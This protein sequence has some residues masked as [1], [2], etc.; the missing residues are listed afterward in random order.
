MPTA[1]F[2]NG[3]S[4]QA[5]LTRTL[6]DLRIPKDIRK[7]IINYL[8]TQRNR[9]WFSQKVL[10][11]ILQGAITH[12]TQHFPMTNKDKAIMKMYSFAGLPE[13]VAYQRHLLGILALQEKREKKKFKEIQEAEGFYYCIPPGEMI[14]P[15]DLFEHLHP[16]K[17]PIFS[18]GRSRPVHPHLLEVA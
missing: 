11:G 6:S 16:T 10:P 12:W 5:S 9:D 15:W 17:E 1:L 14:E 13:K 2:A 3:S 8:L 4:G 7:V 18:G